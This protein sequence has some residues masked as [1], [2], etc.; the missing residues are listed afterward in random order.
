VNRTT[1]LQKPEQRLFNYL[2]LLLIIS[3]TPLFETF[4]A[5]M[6]NEQYSIF[7]RGKIAAICESILRGEIGVIAGSRRITSLGFELF[8]NHDEDFIP[9]VAIDSETDHLPVDGE[10]KN[11]SNDS[12]KRKD[13][14]IAEFESISKE[15][16]FK[17][18]KN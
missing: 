13:K 18:C 12:L 9:F 3:I 4:L 2:Y 6:K 10:R 11:W 1:P 5:E 14:E 15:E 16:A 17:A 7:I 8:D